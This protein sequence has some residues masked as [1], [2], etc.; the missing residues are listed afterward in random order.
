M[1]VGSSA[2]LELRT[3]RAQ[4][5][6]RARTALELL[7]PSFFDRR[8]ALW[9]LRRPHEADRGDH[10]QARR[11][12]DARAR[13][14]SQRRTRAV[15][16]PRATRVRRVGTLPRRRA[17]CAGR[18]RHPTS[19]LRVDRGLHRYGS[20]RLEI[21]LHAAASGRDPS[22]RATR[23]S[24]TTLLSREHLDGYRVAPLERR[25][26][27]S[28]KVPSPLCRLSAS[29]GPRLDFLCAAHERTGESRARGVC[30]ARCATTPRRARSRREPS[31]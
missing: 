17:V 24:A 31:W 3:R 21:E 18:R 2:A 29:T 10:R 12:E 15:A 9:Q 16:G 19:R 30:S 11:Q 28:C 20:V 5:P 25:E 23:V 4:P 27:V 7:R 8:L 22:G 13:R 1:R 14:F 6:A 26:P